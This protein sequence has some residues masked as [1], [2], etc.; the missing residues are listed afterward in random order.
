MWALW[1]KTSSEPQERGL[2]PP[3]RAESLPELSL[4]DCP[5]GC[6]PVPCS[7]GKDTKDRAGAPSLPWSFLLLTPV[8]VTGAAHGREETRGH[9]RFLTSTED[10]APVWRPGSRRRRPEPHL[11]SPWPGEPQACQS[12]QAGGFLEPNLPTPMVMCTPQTLQALWGSG[13]SGLQAEIQGGGGLTC[14]G[15]PGQVMG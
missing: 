2:R 13:A 6:V 1:W 5:W 10:R 9:L 3:N 4:L 12:P 15:V 14:E 8:P 7:L 11:P